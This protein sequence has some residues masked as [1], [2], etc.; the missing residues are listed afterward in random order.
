MVFYKLSS[1]LQVF[2][3]EGQE[4]KDSQENIEYTKVNTQEV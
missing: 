1:D 4:V 2:L 3:L